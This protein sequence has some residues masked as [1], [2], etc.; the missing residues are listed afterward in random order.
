MQKVSPFL[1]FDH[2][3]EE[4]VNLYTSIF[5]NSKTGKVLRMGDAVLTVGFTLGGQEFTA[6]NG[7]PMFKINPSISFYTVCETEAE[8]DAA[9][10]KLVDGGSVLMP[11]DKYPWSEKY[12]WLQDRYGVSWQITLGKVADL[13]QRFTP[14]MMFTGEQRGRAEEAINFY[15]SM[16]KNSSTKLISR[17]GEGG[18]D[19]AG[20]INHAQFY[21]DGQAFIVMDSAM[22]HR[23]QFN[24]AVSF[25]VNCEGQEEVD[26]FW[27]KLTTDGG[28]ESQCGWLKDKFGVS[29]QVVPTELMK[30]LS[31]PDPARAQ[32]AMGAMMQM[33]KIDIE[34]LRQA[35]SDDSKQIITVEAVV[36]A[37]V[38]KAWQLWTQPEH[39][40]RWNNASDDWHTP[41]AENDLRPGGS[42]SYRMEAKDGS[43]GFDFD[44]VY[45]DVVENQRI[46]YTLG[47]GRKVQ[48]TFS[49]VDNGT[50]VMETFEAESMNSAELQRGGWQAILD[51]FKKHAASN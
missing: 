32:R 36:H 14:A 37:P 40:T 35:A 34:K 26:F 2:Q 46:E 20:T 8:A 13:G 12:G 6:L 21:L 16:F 42:F 44:G 33:R 30:L 31:D 9:W 22:S 49:E 24:E 29:W 7:G 39:I 38:E 15:S 1:W 19:P 43:F 17:Y 25:V 5:P 3:A 4:A 48:V 51:N 10:Q 47:D 27:N 23:F 18:L 28:A 41:S 50:H 11:L 45:D